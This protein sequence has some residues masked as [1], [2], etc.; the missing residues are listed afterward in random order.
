ML[1]LGHII[2]PKL[3][4]ARRKVCYNYPG[5]GQSL[6]LELRCEVN[7]KWQDSL[8][9]FPLELL[10]GLLTSWEQSGVHPE[11]R[12]RWRSDAGPILPF[13]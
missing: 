3:A 13:I 5:H 1:Y 11:S 7:S 2:M 8:K 6:S 10:N 9:T 12:F 4:V